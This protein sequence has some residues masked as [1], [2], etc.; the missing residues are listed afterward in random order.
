[1]ERVVVTG[2]GLVTPCGIGTRQTMDA[3]LAGKS[4]AGPIT[5]F[6]IDDHYPTRIAAEVKDYNAADWMPRKKVTRSRPA[7]RPRLN[8][9]HSLKSALDF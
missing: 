5:L 9:R 7:C 2:I 8:S 3:L 6:E 1:M 4:G